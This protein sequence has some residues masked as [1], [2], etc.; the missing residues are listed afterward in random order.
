MSVTASLALHSA[1]PL[2]ERDPK[3]SQLF[4]Q[5]RKLLLRAI[6]LKSN[7]VTD[8]VLV[9]GEHL[10]RKVAWLAIVVFE[11]LRHANSHLFI[12]LG[13]AHH[14]KLSTFSQ[15]IVDPHF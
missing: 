6:V 4:L 14:V 8:F 13:R 10:V 2:D 3:A 12:D 15:V 11:K 1:V 9:N 7:F 5:V